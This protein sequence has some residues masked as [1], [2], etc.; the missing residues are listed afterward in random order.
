[1]L[2]LIATDKELTIQKLTSRPS[3]TILVQHLPVWGCVSQRTLFLFRLRKKAILVVFSL[4]QPQYCKDI[5]RSFRILF[6]PPFTSWNT[7]S[8][9]KGACPSLLIQQSSIRS[10]YNLSI[11]CHS[12]Q[13]FPYN[14]ITLFNSI[15]TI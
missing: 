14:A 8:L 11:T 10:T 1:M 4:P 5:F 2:T 6:Y 13:H 15:H 12:Q 3:G 7:C 9:P